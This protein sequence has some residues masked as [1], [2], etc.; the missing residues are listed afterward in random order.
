MFPDVQWSDRHE[1][2]GLAISWLVSLLSLLQQSSRKSAQRRLL[3]GQFISGLLKPVV[4]NMDDFLGLWLLGGVPLLGWLSVQVSYCSRRLSPHESNL[5]V[6]NTQGAVNYMLSVSP[7]VMLPG[8]L[9]T[10]WH[11]RKLSSLTSIS[12]ATQ[13]VLS[14]VQSNGYVPKYFL[15]SL[16]PWTFYHVSNDPSII[17]SPCSTLMRYM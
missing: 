2:L 16:Q 4:P 10:G 5:N 17:S 12:Q 3:R 11:C 9:I 13:V 6:G 8:S 7:R 1:I 15:H 14:F